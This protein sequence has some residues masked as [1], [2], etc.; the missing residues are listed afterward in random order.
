MRFLIIFLLLFAGS[1]QAQ[2]L[3]VITAAKLIPL[4]PVIPPTADTT[5]GT[6][7]NFNPSIADAAIGGWADFNNNPTGPHAILKTASQSGITV[8]TNTTTAWNPPYGGN[9]GYN[10]AGEDTDDGGGFFFPAN[11]M[12]SALYNNTTYTGATSDAT[13]RVSG[14]TPDSLYEIRLLPSF[15]LA[16]LGFNSEMTAKVIHRDGT[17][18]YDRYM[19]GSRNSGPRNP[20]TAGVMIT[21]NTSKYLRM[22]GYADASGYIYIWIG[23]TTYAD[24]STSLGSANAIS[25][26]KATI[27]PL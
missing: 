2:R 21:G 7:S 5:Y 13:F 22:F 15:D 10:L 14:L 3:A 18:T 26:R 12:R 17:V 23:G 24:N 11:V 19:D 6:A 25:I 20:S 27:T 8:T 9:S 16:L 1:L 4:P